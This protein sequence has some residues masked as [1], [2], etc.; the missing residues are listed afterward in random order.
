MRTKIITTYAGVA[1]A[2]VAVSLFAEWWEG[3]NPFLVFA[4]GWCGLYPFGVLPGLANAY[5][6]H[7]AGRAFLVHAS[8]GVLGLLALAVVTTIIR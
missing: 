2:M 5:R 1:F 6:M 7:L 3:L 8:V 4:V